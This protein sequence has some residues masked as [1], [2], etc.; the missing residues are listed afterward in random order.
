MVSFHLYGWPRVNLYTTSHLKS[1][2]S[3]LQSYKI[4]KI[5][6]R[7]YVSHTQPKNIISKKQT[8]QKREK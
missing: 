3:S 6:H 1:Y 8:A 7:A 5:Y 4:H 2:Q